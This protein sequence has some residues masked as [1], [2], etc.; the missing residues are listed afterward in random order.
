MKG[1]VEVTEKQSDSQDLI[2]VESIL[3]VLN[4]TPVLI[5]TKEIVSRY[6]CS[7]DNLNIY[8][9]ES[10]EEIKELIKQAQ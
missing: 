3:R 8:V 1:F 5:I 9:K 2:S 10:Y 6:E 7:G 4:T